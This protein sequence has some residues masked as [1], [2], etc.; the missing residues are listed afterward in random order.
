MAI[1]VENRK[2]FAPRVI[3]ALDE[4]VPL[5]LGTLGF[6]K[7]TTGPMKKFDD[8]FSGLYTIHER[9]GQTDTGRQQRP[10][11]RITSRGKNGSSVSSA[12]HTITDLLGLMEPTNA[13]RNYINSLSTYLNYTAR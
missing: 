1:S 11:L 2:I 13:C 5:E 12:A 9:D 8:I 4:G 3:N 7:K 10:R 6:K